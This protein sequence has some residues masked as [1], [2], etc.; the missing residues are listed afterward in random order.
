[1]PTDI[2]VNTGAV[3]IYA[4]ISDL[5]RIGH[6]DWITM[7]TLLVLGAWAYPANI[8]YDLL[9]S[10]HGKTKDSTES[11]VIKRHAPQSPSAD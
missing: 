4:L 8:E 11:N 7:A 5:S 1:M 3:L 9:H 6:F 2:K 10:I